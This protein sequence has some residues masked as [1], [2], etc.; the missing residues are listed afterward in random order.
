MRDNNIDPKK[1]KE[2]M[3][4]VDLIYQEKGN[5]S[6]MLY[7]QLGKRLKD[8]KNKLSHNVQET[9]NAFDAKANKLNLT[10]VT[11]NQENFV[12]EQENQ[13]NLQMDR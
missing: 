4:I 3:T 2:G 9:I 5:K 1:L 11:N 8:D 6:P 10:N 12:Q 7:L 13:R